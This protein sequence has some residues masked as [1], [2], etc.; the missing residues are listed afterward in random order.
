MPYPPTCNIFYF[1]GKT[2]GIQDRYKNIKLLRDAAHKLEVVE[3][4]AT[5]Y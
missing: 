5:H 1:K 4:L 3:R 2:P